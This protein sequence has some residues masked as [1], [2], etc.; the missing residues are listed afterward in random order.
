MVESNSSLWPA[1]QSPA[2][3]QDLI[4]NWKLIILVAMTLLVLA[5]LGSGPHY[6]VLTSAHLRSRH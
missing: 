3:Y 1:I 4:M 6:G 5:Y 2:D